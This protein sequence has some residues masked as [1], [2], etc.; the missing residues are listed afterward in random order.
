[1]KK[2][3]LAI[4]L[5]ITAV[6]LVVG[7]SISVIYTDEDG[8]SLD[9]ATMAKYQG[10]HL[11][12]IA[13]TGRIVVNE[14]GTKQIIWDSPQLPTLEEAISMAAQAKTTGDTNLVPLC[15][16]EYL[17]YL[18]TQE[19]SGTPTNN[20]KFPAC[21]AIPDRIAFG[22]PGGPS[23]SSSSTDYNHAGYYYDGTTVSKGINGAISR[24]DPSLNS[25]EFVASRFLMD[26]YVSGN[27]YWLES[28]WAEYYDV[29]NDH[30]QHVYTQQCDSTQSSCLWH[31]FDSVCGDSYNTLVYIASQSDNYW[32]SFCWNF[33]SEVW[34]TTWSNF[35]SGDDDA[36]ALEALFEAYEGQTGTITMGTVNFYGLELVDTTTWHDWTTAYSSDTQKLQE[37]GYTVATNSAYYNFN[38][39][40]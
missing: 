19:N 24:D 39:N 26:R 25:G 36:S 12:F 21:N 1:M 8:E 11:N 30:D 7:L 35:D 17:E 18:K 33:D 34:V 28:G 31:S 4:P 10:T 2:L 38:V 15:T 27:H 23:Q 6:V 22:S 9:S 40:N 3:L 16:P 37:G 14:H 13:E 5:I 29:F 32:D 20:S